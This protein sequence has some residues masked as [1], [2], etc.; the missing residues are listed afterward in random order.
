MEQTKSN[1]PP[2]PEEVVSRNFSIAVVSDC[3]GQAMGRMLLRLSALIPSAVPVA[4]ES[5][6]DE[7]AAGN[8]VD[9][10]DSLLDGPG[11]VVCNSA[12]RRDT[13]STNGSAIVFGK[14]GNI[15]L[16]STVG[17]LGLLK[18]LVPSLAVRRLDVDAF[19]QRH[20]GTNRGKF[21][22]RGLE[23]IPRV[24][25][26][27]H[28]GTDLTSMSEPQHDD[29]PTIEPCIWLVDDIEGKPTNLKLSIRRSELTGFA[30]GHKAV[31]K[32]GDKEE[33]PIL[34]YERL[35]H[36]PPDE[37]GL[38]ESSSGLGN[39]R[40]LEI[41]VMGGS[42]AQRLGAKSGDHIKIEITNP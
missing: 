11:A 41:A 18:Q 24:L 2:T 31:V 12:P 15:I 19:M 17:V 10:L 20:G 4:M 22:F 40:F 30:A 42:A 14:V 33:F 34:C 27:L 25:A 5:I 26:E 32:I 36:V 16:V 21:N 28:Q 1:T 9:A 7:A 3:G 35:T 39:E 23:V 38:Y 13:R 29:F 8:I 37:L 6:T